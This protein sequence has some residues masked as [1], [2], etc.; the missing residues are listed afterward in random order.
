MGQII[1]PGRESDDDGEGQ[2]IV[3]GRERKRKA[4]P[5][6]NLH[7]GR[8]VKQLHQGQTMGQW[9][10]EN[11]KAFVRREEFVKLLT[12]HDMIVQRRTADIQEVRRQM[13]PHRRLW[14]AVVASLRGLLPAPR[15]K[16]PPVE[17]DEN[18]TIT[19]PTGRAE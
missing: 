9:L 1:V 14:R 16:E 3:P 2:I 15:P 5:P 7:Q 4:G 17:Q 8:P 19:V 11:P 6:A 13:L 10:D 12:V 18:G